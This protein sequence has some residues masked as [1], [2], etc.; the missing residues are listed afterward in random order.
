MHWAEESNFFVL[1]VGQHLHGLAI[2]VLFLILLLT[3]FLIFKVN[4]LWQILD[5]YHTLPKLSRS[6]EME[7]G[8]SRG[9]RGTC[10]GNV[11]VYS[12]LN[13]P[14]QTTDQAVL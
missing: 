14:L 5:V 4:S 12:K 7:N 2:C 6:D 1:D 9:R 13:F 11:L 3:V 10:L 8:G